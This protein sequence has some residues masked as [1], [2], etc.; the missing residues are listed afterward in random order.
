MIS[1][2]LLFG[3]AWAI[4]GCFKFKEEL[5]GVALCHLLRGPLG[6]Y[7]VYL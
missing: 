1:G 7:E 5:Y 4:L 3:L 2:A 6:C